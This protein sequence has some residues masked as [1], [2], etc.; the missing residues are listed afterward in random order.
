MVEELLDYSRSGEILGGSDS[1]FNPRNEIIPAYSILKSPNYLLDW[2][3]LNIPAI[4]NEYFIGLQRFSGVTSIPIHT[5]SI[6]SYAYNNVITPDIG[7]TTCFYDEEDRL[8]NRI[9]YEK[10]CWYYHNTSIPHNIT[11][12]Y[13]KYRVAV[14]IFKVD[15]SR[16]GSDY[17]LSKEAEAFLKHI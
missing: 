6:R 17:T 13:N 3:K 9:M 7:T 12:L 1:A 4:T 8:L 5:D 11:N 16:I 10:N 2:V 14:T 15:F